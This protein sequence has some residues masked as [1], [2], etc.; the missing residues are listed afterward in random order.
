ME[1]GDIE[2]SLDLRG[3]GK[4]W[5]TW[6]FMG[7]VALTNGAFLIKGIDSSVRDVNLRVKLI[8]NA[9]EVKYFGFRILDS[10]ATIT[11][12]IRNWQRK[13]LATITAESSHFDIDLLIPKEE[14][15]PIRDFLEDVA[16]SS[17]VTAHASIERGTYKLLTF[18]NLSSRV[19][20][21]NGVLDLDRITAKSFAG[22]VDGR[23]VIR[24]P[25]GK[26]ASTE[27]AVRVTGLPFEDVYSLISDQESRLTGPLF[28]TGT[29]RGDG[30]HPRGVSPSLN[31]NSDFR[32]ENGR[33]FKDD[34]RAIWKILSL[35]HVPA[36]LQGKVDLEKD[37]LPFDQ[38]T[39]SLTVK[40][41]RL[42]SE[43]LVL[44][45]P[46]IKMTAAGTYDIPTDRL[47]YIIA[48]SP[49]GPYTSLLKSIPLFGQL[50]KG[51]RGGLATALFK[52]KG[53]IRDPEVEYLPMRS[54]ASGLGGL[55]KLAVDILVNVVK[56]PQ[57]MIAPENNEKP[58]LDRVP[59]LPRP[60]SP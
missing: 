25:K 17:R 9:A 31:G 2:V 44:D 50:I 39:S 60:S 21:T 13:P 40:G 47:D 4:D 14:R 46:V 55:A 56:I 52:V 43:N 16:A 41:G 1:A 23:V 53:S 10:D 28:L 38:I 42:S 11:G 5:K 59:E 12:V 20:I 35:L 15:S 26:P 24:L 58:N 30:R 6:N 27:A 37:G 19:N 36:L 22:T 8:G 48:V 49:F 32:I 34:S 57:D 45:S 33:I 29:L 54:F 3:K 7:W 18:S 51:E